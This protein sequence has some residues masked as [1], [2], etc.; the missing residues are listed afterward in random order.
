MIVCPSVVIVDG[1]VTGGNTMVSDPMA[2]KEVVKSLD[3]GNVVC[4]FSLEVRVV[5]LDDTEL[6]DSVRE[7]PWDECSRVSVV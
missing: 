5:R 3:D 7:V 1:A 6:P 4:V 2:V